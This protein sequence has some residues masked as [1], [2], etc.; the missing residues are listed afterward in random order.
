MIVIYL[1]AGVLVLL[2]NLELIPGIFEMIFTDAFTGTAAA[3]VSTATMVAVGVA[4]AA[5]LAVI[6]SSGSSSSH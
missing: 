6:A 4:A 5:G 1:G 3:G 2:N